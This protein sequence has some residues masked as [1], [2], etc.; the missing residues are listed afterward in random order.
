M[1]FFLLFGF[2]SECCK[3]H[4]QFNEPQKS[5]LILCFQPPGS[6]SEDMVR[7]P[8]GLV[9]CPPP[10]NP[11]DA[12]ISFG[13][14]GGDLGGAPETLPRQ[15]TLRSAISPTERGGMQPFSQMGMQGAV[16]GDYGHMYSSTTAGTLAGK[17][18][19][20]QGI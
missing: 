2:E 19:I 6:V 14:T 20:T 12:P 4:R 7:L 16:M 9:V 5:N 8:I 13:G 1:Y 15:F 3:S 11:G 17:Y 18:N 10:K